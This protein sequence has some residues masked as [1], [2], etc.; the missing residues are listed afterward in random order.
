M[1]QALAMTSR[2]VDGDTGA[3]ATGVTC[4]ADGSTGEY[5]DAG[6]DRRPHR[7]LVETTAQSD[8]ARSSEVWSTGDP[9]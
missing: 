5:H 3:V 4:E 2:H 6:V 9:C 8:G 7:S 1:V